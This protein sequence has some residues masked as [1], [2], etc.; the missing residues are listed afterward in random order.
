M[1]GIEKG[2]SPT[3]AHSFPRKKE[4]IALFLKKILTF[5][6]KIRLS[7]FFSPFILVFMKRNHTS[8]SLLL[9]ACIVSLCAFAFVN[10][11]TSN[12]I[13]NSFNQLELVKSKVECEDT[14]E[15]SDLSVPDVTVLGRVWEIA[16]HFLQRAH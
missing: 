5:V 1:V 11:Q 10:A 3:L 4:K 2:D 8:K 16:Q 14:T 9:A 13:A 15:S 6:P 7:R 12:P